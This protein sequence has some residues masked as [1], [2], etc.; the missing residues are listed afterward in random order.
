[1]F[2]NSKIYVAGH[3]GLLGSAILR[4]LNE[5]G[6]T[7]LITCS[8]N[9]LDLTCGE[10][11]FNFFKMEKPEYVFLAAG[12][13]GGI[14]S[15]KR[16]PADYLH[17]NLAIQDNIFESAVKHGVKKVI[18]YGSSCTY[19]RQ[20]PQPIKEEYLLTGL[21]ESTSQAYAAAKIA[22]IIGCR[23]YNIQCDSNIF[24]SLIPSTMYGPGD[25]FSVENGHVISSLISRF[26][27]AKINGLSEVTLWGSGKPR[28]EFIY[29]EDIADASIFAMENSQKLENSHYNIGSG[30]DYSIEEIASMVMQ[31]VGY[32]GRIAWDKNKPDGTPQKLLDSSRF[33]SLGW[34]AGI[35]LHEGLQET[36]KWYQENVCGERHYSKTGDTC[37]T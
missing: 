11:V 32:S 4:R 33:L 17:V 9:D 10:S 15:N 21:L 26:Y 28:R 30:I 8:H 23:A 35:D 13:V 5:K 3:R 29:S 31:I 34:T 37:A 1:M 19:P 7:N 24:I 22:G 20:C 36:F 25:N 14:L 18:F 27:Q 6:Y 16:Y 2:K 12:K